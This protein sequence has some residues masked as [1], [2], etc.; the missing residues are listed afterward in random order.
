MHMGDGAGQLRI[1]YFYLQIFRSCDSLCVCLLF[2]YPFSSLLILYFQCFPQF[3]SFCSFAGEVFD[4]LVAH[5]RM[6]EKEARA[7]FRQVPSFL[8]LQCSGFTPL[9]LAVLQTGRCPL[10]V[11]GG[12]KRLCCVETDEMS[13]PTC[14]PITYLFMTVTNKPSTVV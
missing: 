1:S 2:S 8:P 10:C 14:F 13:K 11:L 7:K 4:Y 6:K 12:Q 9:L 5:G 3:L